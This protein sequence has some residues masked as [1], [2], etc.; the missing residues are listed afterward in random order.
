VVV[1]PVAFANAYYIAAIWLPDLHSVLLCGQSD[2]S[3]V[4]GNEVCM[5]AP[6]PSGP[7]GP[8]S[9][10][11]PPACPAPNASDLAW[12]GPSL[13]PS[14]V[15]TISSSP[16]HD[17]VIMATAGSYLLASGQSTNCYTTFLTQID[18]ILR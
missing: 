16:P 11:V 1:T 15:I 3:D 5:G 6:T 2:I 14:T 7:W 12:G 10:V 9:V 8:I 13:V 18:V 4:T 17:K